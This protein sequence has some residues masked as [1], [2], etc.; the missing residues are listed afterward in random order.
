MLALIFFAS[1]VSGETSGHSLD[2][3]IAVSKSIE[4]S[5]PA[6]FID[7]YNSSVSAYS[8][9]QAGGDVVVTVNSDAAN[10][11]SLFNHAAIKGDVYVGPKANVK[12]SIRIE[13]K[14]ELTGRQ[15]VLQEEIILPGISLPVIPPFTEQSI[16][17]L[18][19]DGDSEWIIDASVHLDDLMIE[20]DA[21]LNVEGNVII[22]VDGDFTIGVNAHL[23]ITPGST[24]DMYVM[25]NC[26]IG[27]R[28]NTYAGDPQALYLFMAGE[29]KLFEMS[30]NA[31]VFAVLQNPEGDVIIDNETQFF[32]R[33]KANRLQSTGGIHIDLD[34]GFP[35]QHQIDGS[36][37]L[38]DL[39]GRQLIADY[40]YNITWATDGGIDNVIIEYSIDD[41]LNW[42]SIDTVMNTGSYQWQVPQINSQE[43]FLRLLD[44]GNTSSGV[45]SE[46]FTIY[47]CDLLYDLNGDCKVDALDAR[48]MAKEWLT[49]GNPFE[50]DCHV[51]K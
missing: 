36:L 39:A 35:T 49:C 51:Q 26:R 18:V 22:L 32:G 6:A 4:L 38:D 27:G 12:R 44:A 16:G 17:D 28:A 11:L 46:A 25:G 50:T 31:A 37:Q 47:V 15:Q 41:G 48:L 43:C 10:C 21:V 7:S 13:N 34:S 30:G 33:I 14:S 29:G 24:L 1:S 40:I 8:P 5:G 20:D 45:V 23:E 3:G 19:A 2:P 9:L 42:T